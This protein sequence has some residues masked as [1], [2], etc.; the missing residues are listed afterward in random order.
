M[1]LST[2]QIL[3]NRDNNQKKRFDTQFWLFFV[4]SKTFQSNS[5][6][7]P[8]F[9]VVC[10]SVSPL[11]SLTY[12]LS[13][14]VL[15]CAVFSVFSAVALVFTSEMCGSSFSV[16]LYSSLPVYLTVSRVLLL[17]RAFSKSSISHGKSTFP[18]VRAR[19]L[20]WRL[21]RSSPSSLFLR[22]SRRS[23]T[24]TPK[25]KRAARPTVTVCRSTNATATSTPSP[26][27]LAV[28]WMD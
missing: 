15:H 8:D 12:C 17:S 27:H 6:Q 26:A 9:S 24:S 7:R 22:F 23:P 16:C 5:L 18:A 28:Q 3:R 10:A 19:I 20:R 4:S 11:K 13:W 1:S 21:R 14:F 2:S 25:P